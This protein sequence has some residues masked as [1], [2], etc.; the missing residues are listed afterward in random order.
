[1]S[2]Y[3]GDKALSQSYKHANKH[4]SGGSDPITPESIGAAPAPFKPA[5]KSYLTFS[6]PNSLTLK[7]NDTTKHWDGTLEYFASDKT[8]T[9]WDGTTTLSSV[10]NDGEYVLYL[11]GTGNTKITGDNTNY[12]WVFT[13]S[14]ISCIGNIENL[15]DYATVESGAHPTMATNCYRSMFRDC[16]SLTQAPALPAT[17]LATYCY[18]SMFLGCT[19]LTQAPDLPATTLASSCY[20]YMFRDCTSLTQ[21]PALPATTLATNCY[22]HMFSGCTALT[23]A[24]ALPAT[25]LA[26]YCYNSIFNGCA[27]LKLSSTQTGEYTQEYRIPSSGSGTTATNALTDMFTS[28]GGT[29]TGTPEINTTYYLSSDNMVVRETE[30]ATLNGYVGSMI[31]AAIGNAIGGSY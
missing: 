14:D 16:T 8:W 10:D 12:K 21:T 31:D 1:M 2:L 27:S 4:A 20:R 24:P 3:Q 11:R 9:A 23:Q 25:T 22:Q 15:L 28:T 6:S 30:I 17:T 5:G 7:V 13:G 26:N 29:F 19:S 18:H